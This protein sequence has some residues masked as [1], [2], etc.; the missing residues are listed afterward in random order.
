MSRDSAKTWVAGAAALAVLLALAAW[1][2][3]IGPERAQAQELRQQRLDTE[4]T[5]SVLAARVEQLRQQ[6]AELPE[7]QEELVTIGRALPAEVALAA[8]TRDLDRLAGDSGAT[9]MSIAPGTPVPAAP[10]VPV[11]PI[12]PAAPADP[13]AA[14]VPAP[15]AVTTVPISL[16]LVGGYTE[17]EVFLRV[18]QTELGRDF[19]VTGLSLT[20]EAPSAGGGGKPATLNGDVTLTVSGSVFVLP[21]VD[22]AGSGADVPPVPAVPVP[23]ALDAGTASD[24]TT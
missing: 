2:L 14:A 6:F 13:A 17:A 7:R 18:L 19:L 22:G 1:F 20:A 16:T 3:L 24:E 9:L 11:A 21:G 8:L 12:D 23:G 5:N 4:A 15:V 10:P